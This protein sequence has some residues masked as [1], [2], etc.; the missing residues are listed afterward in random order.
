MHYSSTLTK[1]LECSRQHYNCCSSYSRVSQNSHTDTSNTPLVSKRMGGTRRG[2]VVGLKRSMPFRDLCH[3][4][5]EGMNGKKRTPYV[6]RQLTTY[7]MR[8]GSLRR[9]GG[10]RSKRNRDVIDM[11]AL[12]NPATAALDQ[13]L[14]D[15][16][17]VNDFLF[18]L[19]L[20]TD[21]TTTSS[22][23]SLALPFPALTSKALDGSSDTNTTSKL[24]D[25]EVDEVS[26]A[27]TSLHPMWSVRRGNDRLF[28]LE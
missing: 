21:T 26:F 28:Y 24:S 27:R 13:S 8:N 1:A 17:T 6:L 16:G 14:V 23:T 5:P 19:P 10:D 18:V 3:I 12:R 4:D 11:W 9:G 2:C 7:S 25:L 22:L 20:L 15:L